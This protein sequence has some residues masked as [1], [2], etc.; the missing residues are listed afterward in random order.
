[1][2]YKRIVTPLHSHFALLLLSLLTRAGAD[3]CV[4]LSTEKL[5]ELGTQVLW[6]SYSYHIRFIIRLSKM[7]PAHRRTQSSIGLDGRVL[8]SYT[9]KPAAY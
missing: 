6:L 3:E 9:Y 5:S 2:F 4:Q 7:V 8:S 1:M